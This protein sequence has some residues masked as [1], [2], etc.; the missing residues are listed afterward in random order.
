M[1]CAT[2]WTSPWSSCPGPRMCP[3]APSPARA[4]PRYCVRI[5]HFR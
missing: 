4:D 5:S 2:G 1:S 3:P